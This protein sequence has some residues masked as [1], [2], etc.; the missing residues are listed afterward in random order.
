M[1][2]ANK[3]NSL[4]SWQKG[5]PMLWLLLSCCYLLLAGE[6]LKVKKQNTAVEF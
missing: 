3:V 4:L 1:H 5:L 6:I 2:A